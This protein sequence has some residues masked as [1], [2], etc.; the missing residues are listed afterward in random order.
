MYTGDYH[1]RPRQ[2]G[3]D[4]DVCFSGHI[5]VTQIPLDVTGENIQL[6]NGEK[7]NGI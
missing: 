3:R 4:V 6:I 2:P 1:T 7:K 5:A